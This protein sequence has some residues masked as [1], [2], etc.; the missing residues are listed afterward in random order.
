MFSHHYIHPGHIGVSYN[1]VPDLRAAAGVP[2]G[3]YVQPTLKK[4]STGLKKTTKECLH[5]NG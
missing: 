1:E 5:H 3:D 4:L 2:F